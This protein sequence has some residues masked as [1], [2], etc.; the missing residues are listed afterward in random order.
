MALACMP[1][2]FS[3]GNTAIKLDTRVPFIKIVRTCLTRRKC[4]VFK[5][6]WVLSRTASRKYDI[7][8]INI[9]F[10]ILSDDVPHLLLCRTILD[11]IER[12]LFP[13]AL[14]VHGSLNVM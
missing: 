3:S 9:K 11:V 14:L 1:I 13:L 2:Q 12:T 4:N 10:L 7:I 5:V 8:G 6:S